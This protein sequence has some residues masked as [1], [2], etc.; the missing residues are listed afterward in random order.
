M[1]HRPGQSSLHKGPD[2]ISRNPEGRD[3]LLLAKQS[4]WEGYR[5]RIKGISRA[6][7][8]G[9]ADDSEI[10]GLDTNKLAIQDPKSLEPLPPE[11]GLAVAL[12]YERGAQEAKYGTSARGDKSGGKGKAKAP[13]SSYQRDAVCGDCFQLPGLGSCK[14]AQ[15]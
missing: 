7:V 6:I 5:D 15:S 4:D 14:Q 3:R 1:L 2:G 13:P 12:H 9:E 8:S 10:E 11:Q